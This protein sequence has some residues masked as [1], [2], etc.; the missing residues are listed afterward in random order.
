MNGVKA[1]IILPSPR[2]LKTIASYAT[3]IKATKFKINSAS[4]GM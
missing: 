3:K 2:T 1:Q 4:W